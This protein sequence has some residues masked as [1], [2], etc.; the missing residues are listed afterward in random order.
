MIVDLRG[1]RTRPLGSYLKGLGVLRLVAEQADPGCRSAWAGPFL[2]FDSEMGADDLVSFFVERYSP[3]PLVSPWNGG[4]GFH[5]KDQQAGISAI[6]ASSTGRLAD[7]R[8]AISICRSLVADPRWS[9]WEKHEQVRACRNLLPDRAVQWID[10]AVVLTNDGRSFPPLLGTGGNVGRLE[11]S[12]NFMQTLSVAL[13]L[14]GPPKRRPKDAPTPDELVVDSLFAIGNP[15]LNGPPIGQFDP[16]RAGG[17]N[18]GPFGDAGAVVNP[19]DF[20]LTFEGALAFA[21]GAARRLGASADRAAMPFMVRANRAGSAN[22]A[23]DEN[24]RGEIWAPLW[25][26]PASA[27][28]VARLIGEGRAD[29]NGGHAADG[30]D[31]ARAVASLGVDRGIDAFERFTFVERHGQN[32][33]AV[34]QGRLTVTEHPGVALLGQLDAGLRA[35]RR[36]R[37]RSHAVDAALRQLEQAQYRVAVRGGAAELLDVLAA[38]GRLDAVVGRSGRLRDEV[39]PLGPLPAS[40]WLPHLDDGSP[41]LRVAVAVASQRDRWSGASPARETGPT[42]REAP[43]APALRTPARYLRPI[44]PARRGW[45]WTPSPAKVPGLG[46][47]PLDQ[48]LSALIDRRAVDVGRSDRDRQVDGQVGV[49]P[50]FA[51][52]VPAP[53]EDVDDLLSGQLDEQRLADVLAGLLL[54]DFSRGSAML[55]RRSS[56]KPPRSP[57]LSLLVPFL[58][59]MAFKLSASQSTGPGAQA[60]EVVLRPAAWWWSALAAGAVDEVA[61]D[62]VRRLAIAGLRPLVTAP[63]IAASAPSGRRVAA[64]LAV[65]TSMA[66]RRRCL[67]GVAR[68]PSAV[69][70]T[71]TA[72]DHEV[73][74]D[75]EAQGVQA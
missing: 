12:N 13:G 70:A 24:D 29:W 63:N 7:Y 32:M 69:D 20:I 28:E 54:L 66:D 46:S 41:E 38:A 5:P 10:A 27:S 9:S 1:C 49:Q 47:A 60:V 72:R 64:A 52:A 19:W 65:P 51:M 18:S 48:V 55:T 22:V 3:T 68:S 4:S 43:S 61:A 73:P 75:A 15:R 58:S 23:D 11:F 44:E 39:P 35:V 62:A 2:Q 16:G 42:D 8:R 33:L 17:A 56:Q 53:I 6:E 36:A 25:T 26:R 67:A 14:G 57:I 74:D 45:R 50:A 71:V 40:E 59:P 21:S 34:P 37:N 30:L 31:M